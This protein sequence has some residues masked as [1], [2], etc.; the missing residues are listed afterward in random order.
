VAKLLEQAGV[1]AIDVAGRGGTSWSEVESH[2][3]VAERMANLARS[4]SNWGIPTADSI[5]MAREG[6][7]G[8]T[9]IASGGIRT[10]IEVAKSIAM[11]AHAAGIAAPLLEPATIDTQ[12][13][14]DK[15]DEVIQQLRVAMFCIGASD[16]GSLRD[17]SLLQKVHR[18]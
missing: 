17:T 13:V 1:A 10:G 2:R 12:A 4:F 16:L 14:V 5:Q 11:G 15:L 6:A 8:T 9:I 3:A 7:P 18:E